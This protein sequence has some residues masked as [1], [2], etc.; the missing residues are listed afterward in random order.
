MGKKTLV[1]LLLAAIIGS[2]FAQG[3][4]RLINYQGKL[5]DPSGVAVT[6]PVNITFRIFAVE[7]GGT[8]IWT[9]AHTGGSAI[10]VTNGLFDVQLGAITDLDI[11]FDREYWVELQIGSEVLTPRE[12]LTTVPYSFRAIYADTA[13]IIGSG[14]VQTDAT[15][16]GDGTTADPL[17]V[18]WGSVTQHTDVTSAGSGAIITT[19]ERANLHAPGSDNQ[20]LFNRVSDGTNT[21]TVASQTDILNFAATG[22]AAVAVNPATGQVTIDASSAGDDWGSQVVQSDATLTGTGVVGNLLRIAADGVNDTHIDWGLGVN[23]VSAV[24][25]PYSNTV[26]GLTATDVQ[27][28]LDE[29]AGGGSAITHSLQDAYDDGAS[30]T[31]ATGTPVSITSSGAT[32]AINAVSGSGRAINAS[33]NSGTNAAVYAINAGTG[34]A[35]Y[36]SGHLRMSGTAGVKIYSTADLNIQLDE[37]GGAGTTNTFFIYDDAMTAAFTV[38]ELGETWARGNI[39]ATN[40]LLGANLSLGGV[41]LSSSA[42]A[43]G[44]GLVGYSNATSGLLATN[45]QS[46]IDELDAAIAAS[47]DNWGSQV[48]QT[49]A[50]LTGNGTAGSPLDIAQQAATNGQVLKWNGTS[51][52]PDND[53]NTTYSAGNGI[54]LSGTTF[55]VAAG[56]G[57]TQDASGLSHAAHTGDATGASA[58]TVVGIQG[59]A[60]A[61]TAPTSNQVLKWNGTNWAPAADDGGTDSQNLS[62]TPATRALGISGGTGVTLPLFNSTTAGLTP[63]SGGGTVNYLRA[64]GTW[65]T[66]PDENTTYSAGNG[67]SLATTTFSVAGGT[68]LTQE[69]SGLAL[70]E[71]YAGQT[72]EGALWYHGTTRESGRLYG[73]TTNPSSTTRLNYDGYFYATRLYSNGVQVL[74]GNENITLTGDV[75]G[76]GTTSITTTIADNAVTSAKILDGSIMNAD[77]SASAAIAWSKL[78]SGTANRILM[79]NGSGVVTVAAAPT[80]NYYLKWNGS[81]YTWAAASTDLA[82]LTAGAGLSGTDYNGSTARTFAVNAGNG[83]GISGDDV[84]VN[85]GNGIEIISDAVTVKPADGT[86]NVSAGGVRVGLG[87]PQSTSTSYQLHRNY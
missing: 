78:A 40:N 49:T 79:T 14:A 10:V 1:M 37:G 32:N 5:T 28:A 83:L 87:A 12:K 72:T 69:A 75:T 11:A 46:A 29:I 54:S 73:G 43:S 57:L 27:S 50:R 81:A 74:T 36:S 60:V 86:I 23:Q 20:N 85:A 34:P 47:G 61:S 31:V 6:G 64:D 66:P 19:A 35:I 8:A 68:G 33:N 70:T 9:E 42:A 53:N 55:S 84:V 7:T 17:S 48:A 80:A 2:A 15:I 62:Y 24:D 44:A 52:A 13:Y 63:A 16:D 30:I 41:L 76:S 26:S 3:L 18:N 22:G 67:I 71:I 39:T 4:P 77:I 82:N 56:T 45:V 38:N 25:V 58:L 21:Y 51:W 65:A 59:R